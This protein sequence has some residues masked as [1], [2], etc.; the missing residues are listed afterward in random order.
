MHPFFA[1]DKKFV[2]GSYVVNELIQEF[3][4]FTS[5]LEIYQCHI[6]LLLMLLNNFLTSFVTTRIVCT[7]FLRKFLDGKVN[8]NLQVTMLRS[9]LST[10]G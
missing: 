10:L 5:G 2:I 4:L 9:T 3:A 8:Y 7:P 1:G 6:W